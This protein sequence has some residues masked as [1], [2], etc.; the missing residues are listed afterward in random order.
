ML[1]ISLKEIMP[2]NEPEGVIP[3]QDD[4]PVSIT[5]VGVQSTPSYPIPLSTDTS[6][7]PIAF[8]YDEVGMRG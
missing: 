5:V 1:V 2:T 3:Q 8:C 4:F 6:L 7:Y